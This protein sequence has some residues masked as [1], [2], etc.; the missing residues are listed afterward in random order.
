[1]S[2]VAY[3]PVATTRTYAG[4]SFARRLAVPLAALG[5]IVFVL[6]VCDSDSAVLQEINS[7]T[8]RYARRVGNESGYDEHRRR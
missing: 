8:G 3:A 7:G 2:T 4:H 5:L 1:M 6:V